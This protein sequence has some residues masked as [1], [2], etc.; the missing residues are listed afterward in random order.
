MQIKAG[1]DLVSIER[2]KK[3]IKRSGETFLKKIF[4]SSEISNKKT[5]SL[6]GIFAAKEAVVKALE[7][8]VASWL[9]IEIAKE[10]TG[11]PYLILKNKKYKDKIL[12]VDLSISHDGSCALAIA[13]FL[14][15]D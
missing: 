5:E 12:S 4:L 13:V 7:L 8:P 6:A 2:F 3:A 9:A 10:K 1:C 11:R 14:L 15:K